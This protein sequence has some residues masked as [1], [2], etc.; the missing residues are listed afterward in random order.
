MTLKKWD[1]FRD[2]EEF[3]DRLHRA[4]GTRHLAPP[5]DGGRESMTV[6]DWIPSVD[7]AEDPENYLIKVEIPEVKRQDVKVD[8]QDGVLCIHGERRQEKEEKGRKYHRIERSYGTFTRSFSLPDDVDATKIEAEFHDGMLH[9][10]LPKSEATKPK[11][12]EVQVK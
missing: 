12:I 4:F 1:P 9:V 2:L 5:H 3:S 10:K 6:A 11:A 7:V 8:V